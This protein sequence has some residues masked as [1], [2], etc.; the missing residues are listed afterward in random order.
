MAFLLMPVPEI[1]GSAETVRRQSFHALRTA[2][3]DVH[4]TVRVF[5]DGAEFFFRMDFRV[6]DAQIGSV[7]LGDSPK[8]RRVREIL[9]DCREMPGEI[10]IVEKY[11][12]SFRYCGAYALRSVD[13]A[14]SGRAV[15]EN[16]GL[17]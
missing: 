7:A 17:D 15:R 9:P 12:R 6:A 11:G 1:V 5:E 4:R 2:R 8:D 10:G 3:K 16:E 14:F 13:E